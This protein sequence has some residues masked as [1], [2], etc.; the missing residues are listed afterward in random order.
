MDNTNKVPAG[1]LID[2]GVASDETKGGVAPNVDT[3]GGINL[4]GITEE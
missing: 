3:Q 2:L 1:E 4:G